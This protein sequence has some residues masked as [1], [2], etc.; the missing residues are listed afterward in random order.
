MSLTTVYKV[1]GSPIRVNDDMLA[2]LGKLNLSI[3][4]P[5]KP[6]KKKKAKKQSES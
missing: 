4:N 2:I 3:E 6:V 1:D 5:V